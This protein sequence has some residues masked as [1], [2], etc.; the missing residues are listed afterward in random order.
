MSSSSR[1]FLMMREE[2]ET[3]QLYVPS[4]SKKEIKVKAKEDSDRLLDEGELDV[5]EVFTDATRVAEY[6][7]EFIK[8]IKPSIN[9]SEYGKSYDIKSA[10]ISFRNTGDRLDYE[11][12]EVYK[13]LKEQL[14]AREA[15]L[16]MAYKSKDSIYDGEAAEVMRVGVKTAG[17]ETIVIKF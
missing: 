4:I 2:E 3:G 8:N 6:L 13:E 15:L 1:E 11:Q 17:K 10:N 7:A 16:K 9:E 5:A 14:K 12:D